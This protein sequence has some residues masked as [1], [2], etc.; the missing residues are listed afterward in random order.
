MTPSLVTKLQ[1]QYF[2]SFESSVF[3]FDEKQTLILGRNGKGKTNILEALSLLS[4]GNSFR[5][6]SLSECVR[7]GQDVS[8]IGATAIVDNEEE[9]L[10]MSIVAKHNTLGERSSTRYQR[11]GVKKRKTDVVGV[12]KSVVFRPEDLELI[13]GSPK[14]KRD[15]LDEVLL[16]VNKKYHTALREYERALKHRNKLILQLR[17]G[18]ATRR[19]FLFW[20]ELLI[21]HGDLLT[22]ERARFVHFINTNVS[23]P[24]RGTVHYDS[25]LMT[26]ERLH[27][28]ATQEVAA[29]KTLVGPHKDSLLID[30]VLN[31][32]ETQSSVASFG[33]RGQQR[34]AVLWFKVAQLQFIEHETSIVPILLLDDI[35]SELDDENRSIMFPLFENHQVIMTSAEEQEVLP[36]EYATGSVITL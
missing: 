18:L 34:M 30:V 3:S 24:L 27:T 4:T 14:C 22:R 21:R 26:E 2:R 15:F 16:Q 12:L 23:F 33:S 11:N 36:P 28:Y 7:M 25:S 29:G 1:L 32:D 9:L 20:D 13:T 10:Q 17:E 19:D 31:G 35:F 5:G 8:H 6:R